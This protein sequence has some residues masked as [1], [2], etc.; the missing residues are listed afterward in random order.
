MRDII[1]SIRRGGVRGCRRLAA[2]VLMTALA[3]CAGHE[4]LPA[5]DT[6]PACEGYSGGYTERC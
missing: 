6:N 4:P 2:A 5:S 1:K 3:A